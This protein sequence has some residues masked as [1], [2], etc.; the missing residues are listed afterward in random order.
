MGHT[1]ASAAPPAALQVALCFEALDSGKRGV[2]DAQEFESVLCALHVKFECPPPVRAI[3]AHRLRLRARSLLRDWRVTVLLDGLVLVNAAVI[4][5]EGHLA[6][7]PVRNTTL[8]PGEHGSGPAEYGVDPWVGGSDGSSWP[9]M[10]AGVSAGAPA[11]AV[12]I[13]CT[14]QVGAQLPF[15]LLWLGETGVKL[16]AYKF[17]LLGWNFFDA[18]LSLSGAATGLALAVGARGYAARGL[19][20]VGSARRRHVTNGQSARNPSRDLTPL[21][22]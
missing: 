21:L 20:G 1:H 19:L 22:P 14:A 7:P 18:V 13:S 9:G 5:W 16:W 2:I 15:I 10:L 6:A 3:R 12:G 11:L 8:A 4:G 17:V